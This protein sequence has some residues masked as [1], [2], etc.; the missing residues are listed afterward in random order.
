MAT[1]DQYIDKFF[2][3]AV[4]NDFSRDY[5]FRI[6]Y[7]QTGGPGGILLNSNDMVF[8]RT[9]KL[10]GRNITNQ[11]VKYAGQTFNLPGA[12]EFPGS[13]AYEMEFYCQENS[14]LREK[15]LQE[16]IRTFNAFD[17][18]AGYAFGA[19]ATP[20]ATGSIAGPSSV[21]E[22]TQLNK[23]LSPIARYTLVGVSIRSVGEVAYE[24][25]EG[26]GAIKTF[27]VSFAYHF[28]TSDPSNAT[29]N[30]GL[31]LN[32]YSSNANLRR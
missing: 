25:A 27:S 20:N 4:A 28:F 5:H 15:L 16:S 7:I 24:I 3:N 12:V 19:G 13:E 21:M 18:S 32:P 1:T 22:V 23:L 6:N 14:L 26:S 17:G 9:G 11:T 29:G 31:E 10:P 30:V 2:Q 8:A